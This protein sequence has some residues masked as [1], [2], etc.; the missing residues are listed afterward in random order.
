MLVRILKRRATADIESPKELVELEF[1][2]HGRPDL[3]PSV[4]EGERSR[5]VQIAVEHSASL[6]RDPPRG[7]RLLDLAG[8]GASVIET[9]GATRFS[10][11]RSA[12]R[13]LVTGDE[14]VLTSLAATV[15]PALADRTTLVPLADL[16][17]Y[18]EGRMAEQDP[19]WTAWSEAPP[20]GS[21]WRRLIR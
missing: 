14:A 16:R 17:A 10:F 1:S 19:E 7:V 20:E 4:Y 15:L 8:L 12:H 3:R 5:A 6:L 13:E 21:G 11:T 9:P 18:I 2:R